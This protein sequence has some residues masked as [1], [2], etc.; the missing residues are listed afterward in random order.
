M[1]GETQIVDVDRLVAD[2]RRNVARA[3]SEGAYADDLSSYGLELPLRIAPPSVSYRSPRP[4]LG[5]P[6]T[7]LRRLVLRLVYPALL[8]VVNQANAALQQANDRADEIRRLAG[9]L[10]ER[11]A[12]ETVSEREARR[13]FEEQTTGS[14]AWAR[15]ALAREAAARER[16]QRDLANI[17]KRVESIGRRV[18]LR[19]VGVLPP[20]PPSPPPLPERRDPS[21]GE[22]SGS[23][24]ATSAAGPDGAGVQV[25]RRVRRRLGYNKLCELE[26]F[27]HE[28][29]QKWIRDVF[30]YELD[31]L[32]PEFPLGFEHRK[33]WEIGME[34]R[35]F[36]D[37]GIL[38]DDAEVLG[39]GA[40]TEGTIFWLTNHVGRVV[41]TDLYL[42]AEAW[43]QVAPSAMLTDPGLFCPYQSW[44]PER[45]EVQ[46]MSGLDLLFEDESFDG[47]FCTSSIE[48][49][50]TPEDVQRGAEEMFRVL[51]P[52]GILALTT[53]FRLEGS[54]PG[55]PNSLLFDERL[56]HERVIGDLGWSLVSPLELV[57]SPAT[58]ATRL[59]FAD[60]VNE[61]SQV[62]AEPHY[63]HIVLA[64]EGYLWTSIHL[65]LQKK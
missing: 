57:I 33:F 18:D 15:E 52:G 55:L 4:L 1:A 25:R 13:S 38:R 39:V 2:L 6:I 63:P 44:R 64:H 31:R 56:L 26:D 21:A 11:W 34:T 32:G 12:E 30:A 59:S 50:G 7:F 51:R 28:D 23:S 22:A 47:A 65:A 3:R 17:A 20:I 62:E 29:L 49:F 46:H 54:G 19:A 9:N 60:A 35:A 8:D 45:L 16:V 24:A 58:R 43:S 61:I 42:R 48:H 53:E 10:V 40:G 41:A 14:A 36:A 37:F 27:S 5:W